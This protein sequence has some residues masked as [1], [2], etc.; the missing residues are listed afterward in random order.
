[1][2]CMA[3]DQCRDSGLLLAKDI[4]L[5]GSITGGTA[6]MER[7]CLDRIRSRGIH[8]CDV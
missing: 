6:V 5:H 1:M 7:D 4:A 3:G 8:E 2:I